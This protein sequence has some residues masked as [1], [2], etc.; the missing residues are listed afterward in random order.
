M[1]GLG[2]KPDTSILDNLE[3]EKMVARKAK[4][5]PKAWVGWT[6]N[7]LSLVVKLRAYG[8]NNSEI[9]NMLGR[10]YGSV[11][12]AFNKHPHLRKEADEMRKVIL[13]KVMDKHEV[14]P[15]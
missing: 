15:V 6:M 9:A 5:T 14:G 4:S 7:E 3:F 1:N 12:G 13:K 2:F 10:S 8:A 11:A